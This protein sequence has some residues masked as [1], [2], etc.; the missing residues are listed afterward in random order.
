MNSA[1]LIAERFLLLIHTSL[2]TS[3]RLLMIDEE[4]PGYVSSIEI[5]ITDDSLPER[6]MFSLLQN[7]FA[8]AI[9]LDHEILMLLSKF[10]ILS[11]F[12]WITRAPT[13]VWS[14]SP[15]FPFTT[16]L[17]LSWRMWKSERAILPSPSFDTVNEKPVV[18]L[19]PARV[20]STGV[21]VYSSTSRRN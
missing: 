12:G 6:L 4:R 11:A 5:T 9:A 8:E 17:S 20:I 16:S 15:R 18:G 21:F 13:G 19:P 3:M 14:V 1:V 2:Y 7:D 10:S